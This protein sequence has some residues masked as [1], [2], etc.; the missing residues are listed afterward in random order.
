M[1]NVMRL[2]R[3]CKHTSRDSEECLCITAK[4]VTLVSITGRRE[5]RGLHGR[6]SVE[7]Q[8]YQ[9]RHIL[10]CALSHTPGLDPRPG[11]RI[12]SSRQRLMISV[13]EMQK[14]FSRYTRQVTEDSKEPQALSFEGFLACLIE[15]SPK[16]SNL[17]FLSENLRDLIQR[18]VIKAE[19]VDPPAKLAGEQL[20]RKKTR[21]K[22]PDVRS[23]KAKSGQTSL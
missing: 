22:N 7:T 14:I 6:F 15:C 20:N 9:A 17:S 11:A 10:P 18:Y 8:R 12:S 4:R 13:S 5:C 2:L 1:A 3:F 21:A 23:R 19:K 16:L